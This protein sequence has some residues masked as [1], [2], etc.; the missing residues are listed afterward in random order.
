M[1]FT[2]LFVFLCC[3]VP[4][5]ATT[6]FSDRTSFESS[7][8]TILTD[9]YSP[10]EGYPSGFNMYTDAGMTAVFGQTIYTA[11]GFAN[12]NI[13]NNGQYCA[14]CNG[15]FRLTF[16]NTSV[17]TAQ[18]VLGVG[19]DVVSN[20]GNPNKYYAFVT[21]GDNSTL[22][23]ALSSGA[24]FLGITDPIGIKSIHYGL[25]GGGSTTAGSFI[26]DNLTIG[27]VPEPSLVLPV[28]CSLGLVG[29]GTWRR[30]RITRD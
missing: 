8:S 14:G 6:L 16:T 1:R 13:V 12:L 26:M 17:G 10:A 19:F 9:H 23:I 22:N 27:N 30:R 21:F 25:S 18:G 11:T 4:A 24:S 29:F 5:S 2:R 3:I 28:A 15:S 7:L 20:S